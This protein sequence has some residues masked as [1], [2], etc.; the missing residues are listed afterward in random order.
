LPKIALVGAGAIFTGWMCFKAAAGEALVRSNPL[1]ASQVIP[2][3]PR[4]PLRLALLEFRLKQGN[5]SPAVSR[6]AIHALSEVPLASEPFL[7]GGLEALVARDEERGRQLILEARRRDPRA[8]LPRMLALDTM[9]RQGRVA[10][11]AAEITVISRLLPEA[12]Q[13]TI[14]ELAKFASKPQTRQ[15]LADVLRTDPDMQR[16]VLEHLAGKGTDP[17]IVLGIAPEIRPGAAPQE[18]QNRLLLSLIDK[19]ELGRARALWARFAGVDPARLQGVY[20]PR[21][22]RLP[23]PPPFNWQYSETSAGVAEPTRAP[24]LQ[25]EYYGRGDAELASQLLLLSPGRY[26]IGFRAS[27]NTPGT[28]SGSAVSWG[29]FCHPGKAELASIPIRQLD[30]NP[31]RVGGEFTVP[32]N[33]QAVWLRL[34]G[35]PAE[36]PAAQSITISDLQVQKAAS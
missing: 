36:F 8:Q 29:V 23:G 24:A 7:F 17:E 10:E 18:W 34:I 15:A 16:R 2:E 9:L 4:I 3:D 35:T 11:A 26:R 33:C 5:V 22:Q 31:K 20:D 25:V 1:I 30:Y 12:A 6:R 13:L 27:G 14:P 19:G 32:P 21:F 28:A